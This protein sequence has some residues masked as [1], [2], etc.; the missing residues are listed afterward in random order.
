MILFWAPPWLAVTIIKNADTWIYRSRCT[1][2]PTVV[3]RAEDING[4]VRRSQMSRVV[5]GLVTMS[6]AWLDAPRKVYGA[7]GKMMVCAAADFSQEMQ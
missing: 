7:P 5:E 3:F 1:T 6:P 2:E 4:K